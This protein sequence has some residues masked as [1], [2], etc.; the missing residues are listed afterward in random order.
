MIP[1]S[2]FLDALP[3]RT[4][5]QAVQRSAETAA[6]GTPSWVLG[7]VVDTPL[8]DPDLPAGWV[9]VGIPHDAPTSEATGLTDGGVTAVGA[10]VMVTLDPTGRVVSISSPISLPEGASPTS[11]GAV[12]SVVTRVLA[13]ESESFLT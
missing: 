5:A 4:L 12:V 3:T 8:E 6:Q 13:G 9:R 2:L 7:V 1:P 11:T 10:V